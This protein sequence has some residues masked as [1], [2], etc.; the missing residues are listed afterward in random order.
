MSNARSIIL[1]RIRMAN[2]GR[3]IQA[4][5]DQALSQRLINISRGPLPQWTEDNEQRFISQLQKAG[6]TITKI[7]QNNEIVT[8]ITAYLNQHNL[9]SSLVS[10]TSTLLNGLAWPD[11]LEIAQRIPN[12]HDV[13]VLT[14]AF[15]AVAETGSIVLCSST[16]T[17]TTLNFLPDNFICV[18]NENRIVTHMEDAWDQVREEKIEMPRAVNFITGPSRTA[19]VEQTIQIGAHGPRRLHVI[20]L[21]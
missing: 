18:V 12:A 1:E 2:Q 21:A 14:E 11:N 13:T 9:P 20:L 10:A 4:S 7:Y 6:G 16:E 15:S 5:E 17:P 3:A 8:E 19:D